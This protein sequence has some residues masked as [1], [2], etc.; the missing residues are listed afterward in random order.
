MKNHSFFVNSGLQL[1]LHEKLV[2][3]DDVIKPMF[4]IRK[5]LLTETKMPEPII[6]SANNASYAH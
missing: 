3:N 5:L 4:S 2:E 6:K 1:K